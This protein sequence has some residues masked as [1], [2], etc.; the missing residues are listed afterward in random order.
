MDDLLTFAYFSSLLRAEAIKR[1]IYAF[2]YA[3]V[4]LPTDDVPGVLPDNFLSLYFPL[5]VP[6][7]NGVPGNANLRIAQCP[8][9]CIDALL[10]LRLKVTPTS[11]A[12]D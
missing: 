8:A 3:H 10:D 1:G 7:E 4:L 9:R 2:Q 12:L 11:H 6:F 5:L